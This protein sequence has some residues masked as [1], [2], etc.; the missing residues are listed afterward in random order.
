M[1]DVSGDTFRIRERLRVKLGHVAVGISAQ[2][3][4]PIR[5]KRCLTGY[6]LLSS[7]KILYLCITMISNEMF[8]Q[9]LIVRQIRYGEAKT[10]SHLCFNTRS[11]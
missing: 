5:A 8:V 9:H 1:E 6:N 7:N 10:T 4:C 2:V 3:R 11:P